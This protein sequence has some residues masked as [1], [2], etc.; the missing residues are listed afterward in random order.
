M[1]S[2]RKP[3]FSSKPQI[4][5]RPSLSNIQK[6]TSA[7]GCSQR[8]E[9]MGSGLCQVKRGHLEGERGLPWHCPTILLCPLSQ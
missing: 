9:G 8:V 5:L 6:Q 4:H 2:K 1:V 3:T 7:G